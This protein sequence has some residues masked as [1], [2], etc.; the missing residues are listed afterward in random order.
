MSSAEYRW[1]LF[2]SATV[3]VL[4]LLALLGAGGMLLYR[5]WFS[6]RATLAR[7]VNRG[8]RRNEFHL[9]YQP[10]F[11]TSTRKCIGLEVALRWKNVAYGLRG[12]TWYMDKLVDRRSARKIVAFVLS[13]AERELGHL[14]DGRQLYLM[15][16]LWR[17][18]FEDENCLSLVAATAKS[19]TSCRLVFQVKAEDLSRQLDNI[20]R[21]HEDKVR[22]A[23]SGVRAGTS[24]TASALPVDFEFIK[25]DRDVMGLDESDRLRTLQAIAAAGRQLDVAVIADGVEGSGQYHAVTRAKIDL[26][27]GFFLGKAISAGQLPALF[28]KFDWWQGKHVST[29][30]A[31][32]LA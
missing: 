29:A 24:I 14:A 30:N 18:C 31:G 3:L 12:E 19:F 17:T 27:Q 13:T 7:A 1:V 25:V 26:A 4:A 21:L 16:N 15:V 9:E 22:I 11:Y 20:A 8:L 23:V 28:E 2:V 10:V 32:R 5:R 6:E